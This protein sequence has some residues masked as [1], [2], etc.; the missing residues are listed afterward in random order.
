MFLG[1]LAVIARSQAPEGII[2]AIVCFVFGG[3]Y[4][5]LGFFIQR[6]SKIALGI[7][8]GVMV[9]NL[10]SG[11][12]SVVQGGNSVGLIIPTVFLSQTWEGFKAIQELKSR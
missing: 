10:I 5:L 7:A 12:F 9:L 4:L 11:L 8:I 6:K 3:L 2:L 1:I